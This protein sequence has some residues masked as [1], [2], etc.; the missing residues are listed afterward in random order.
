M[1]LTKDT[2][3]SLNYG[4]LNE[5]PAAAGVTFFKGAAVGLNAATG[6]ARPLQAGD[7]FLGFSTDHIDNS[8]GANGAKR[9]VLLPTGVYKLPVTGVTGAS[10]HQAAVYAFDD[11]TFNINQVVSATT[12]SYIGSIY[13]VE[14]TGVALV[15]FDAHGAGLASNLVKLTDNSGGTASD[16]IAAITDAPTR[17]AIAS[18]AARWNL[19]VAMIDKQ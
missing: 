14:A 16:T 3:R 12:G 2:P 5:H 15:A 13:R 9:V 7:R 1:P 18:L 8:G 11:G 19:L 6:F 4:S 17:N 10:Q